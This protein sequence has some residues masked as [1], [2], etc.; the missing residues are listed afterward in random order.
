MDSHSVTRYSLHGPEKPPLADI[1]IVGGTNIGHALATSTHVSVAF[2]LETPFGLSP[3]IYFGESEGVPFYHVTL[4]GSST[5]ASGVAEQ[6]AL[7]IVWG[8]LH[9][10]GVS[11]V[12]GGATAGSIN[13]A[14][15]LGD[16]VIA[17]D[18][19]DFNID[20]KRSIAADVLG[21]EAARILPR[22]VPADDPLLRKIL[23]EE[24]ARVAGKE[25]VHEGGVIVQAAGG[26]FETE[27]EIRMFERLG[28]D[29]VTMNVPT[30]MAYARQ[31]NI[32]YASLTAISNPAEGL[33]R[34]DWKTLSDLYPR[35][36]AQSIEIYLA[37]IRRIYH[38][39][40]RRRIGDTLRV[41]PEFD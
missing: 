30:E 3:T 12:L 37:A 11:D 5:D 28:G 4:H 18:F 1:C 21:P 14:Y 16:W 35:L 23:G 36:H 27:A 31:L 9:H 13:P 22:Q 39:P 40:E 2:A 7:L 29:L 32:N 38:L 10:L 34:W 25:N 8:A 20:R 17:D 19:I 26:R 33:G 24:T 15:K 6:D 41:H